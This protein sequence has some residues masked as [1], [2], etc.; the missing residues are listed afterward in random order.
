MSDN[1]S[2]EPD[3]DSAVIHEISLCI[4]QA[5]LDLQYQQP[6]L[7]RK[8]YTKVSWYDILN[9]A[10]FMMNLKEGFSKTQD[11]NALPLI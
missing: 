1:T 3:N 9:R 6:E 8:K 4:Y 11:R 10:F 7:L 5:I 2:V